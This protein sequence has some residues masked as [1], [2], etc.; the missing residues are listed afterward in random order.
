MIACEYAFMR[1][2]DCIYDQDI[3]ERLGTFFDVAVNQCGLRGQDAV[4]ALVV[5]GL[6]GQL[7]RQNPGFAVGRSGSELLQWAL[8]A[9]GYGIRVPN[10]SR[11]PVSDDYWTGYMVALLQL[12]SGWTYAQVF[13]RMSYADVREMHSWCQDLPEDEVVENMRAALQER[14]RVSALRRARKAAG[15]TQT[16]LAQVAGVSMRSV[17][18]YEEGLKDI[19]KA[20]AGTVYRFS[21][22][23]GCTM[24][25]LLEPAS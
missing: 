10:S 21:L 11:A 4:D 3:R 24:E 2:N 6:A 1:L 25:D 19:N 8:D 13:E 14:P 18:Q 5:S 23:L 16:Q 17:Q 15:L 7:E 9:C 22:V 12:R 20:A